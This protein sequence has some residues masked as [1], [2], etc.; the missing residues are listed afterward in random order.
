M[1]TTAKTKINPEDYILSV[2]SSSERLEAALK[3]AK[4]SFKKTKLT[5]KDI[6]EAVEKV[7]KKAYEKIKG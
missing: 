4:E 1:K 5:V 6:E 7:R 2:F 3:I